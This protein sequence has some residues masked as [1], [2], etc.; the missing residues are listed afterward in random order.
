VVRITPFDGICWIGAYR[1]IVDQREYK[2]FIKS[3]GK[4]SKTIN[5]FSSLLFFDSQFQEDPFIF[6]TIVQKGED[7]PNVIKINFITAQITRKFLHELLQN[8]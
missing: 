3:V 2:C 1:Q 8:D 7:F 6:N 5:H 4:I